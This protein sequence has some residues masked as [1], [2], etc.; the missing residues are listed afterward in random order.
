MKKTDLIK[1]VVA[2]PNIAP[3]IKQSVLAY[4]E[5]N[6]LDNFYTSFL[7][8]SQYPLTRII[9]ATFPVL[10]KDLK[11]RSFE[12]LPFNHIKKRPYLEIFR[13]FSSKVLNAAITDKL[14]EWNELDFD[15]WVARNLDDSLSFIHVYEHSSL[16]TLKRS[17]KLNIRSFYEQPSIHHQTFSEIIKEQFNNFPVFENS[18]ASL[19]TDK[20]TINRNKRR[21][22][23]LKI[24]D[25]IICNST[26]TKTSLINAGVSEHKIM[27]I[28]L[29]FPDVLPKNPNHK[30]ISSP[31]IFM[32]AGNMSL[33]K[34]T[35][36]LL[37]AWKNLNLKPQ[38]AVLWIIGKNYLP[39][40]FLEGMEEKVKFIDNIPHNELMKIYQ[41]ASVFIHPTLADGFGMVVTE[42]M[43]QGL[44]VI[45]S[46]NCIAPDIITEKINGLLIEAGEQ[47]A[48]ED[49]ILWCL[50]NRNK[51]FEM[52]L[53][54]QQKA[55][56]YPWA[57]YRSNLIKQ[58]TEKLR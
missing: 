43:S 49:S 33:G 57:A 28:P 11:R 27:T 35:H 15:N 9:T 53:A 22:E 2:N 41:Q 52:G 40:T 20:K 34:G 37:N 16:A 50:D 45:A 46:H 51:L 32:Y 13:I 26:F 17:K 31:V 7:E 19:L 23:E 8:H 4:W 39:K 55:M 36:L 38:Q 3:H 48:I 18:S 56:L 21:D 47:K 12:E 58:V 24:A 10:S 6:I 5:A 54:A 29:G 44:P 42:A 14:W 25:N 1:G 30:D